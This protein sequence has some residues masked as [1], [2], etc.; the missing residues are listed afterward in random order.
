MSDDRYRQVVYADTLDYLYVEQQRT[1]AELSKMGIGRGQWRT[2]C[3]YMEEI[4]TRLHS[5]MEELQVK[6]H[7]DAF[8]YRHTAATGGGEEV[9]R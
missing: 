2:L 7:H 1:K 9:G 4:E 5:K 8:K 3:K 6:A